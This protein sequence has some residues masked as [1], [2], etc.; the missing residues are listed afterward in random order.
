MGWWPRVD[1]VNRDG[2]GSPMPS[3]RAQMNVLFAGRTL[4]Q[5][6]AEDT[7]AEL[8][9]RVRCDLENRGITADLSAMIAVQLCQQRRNGGETLTPDQYEALIEGAAL[10]CG[11]RSNF[12]E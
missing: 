2:V 9:D 12:D 7:A 5:M 8:L 1:G 4:R 10:A 3:K 11:V 6:E